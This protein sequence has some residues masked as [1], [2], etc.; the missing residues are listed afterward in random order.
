MIRS[1]R[2][3]SRFRSCAG[4]IA[5]VAFIGVLVA[6][7]IPVLRH[8]VFFIELMTTR[9]P[10]TVQIPVMGVAK[11]EIPNSWGFP[12]SGG[13]SHQGVDIFAKRG[14]P[15]LSSTDGIV[16]R[17]GTNTLGGQVVNVLGPGRQVHYYAHLDRYGSFREGD[18]VFA[19]S[20]IGYVGNTGNARDTPSHL[21]Y[22]V[23]DPAHGAI[24]PWPLL[25]SP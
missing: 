11:R 24:N 19:G 25:K 8:P 5:L 4:A 12:R 14:T 10:A 15:V 9:P 13:R 2:R 17:V 20:I 23:Y 21:H 7:W 3:V 16:V 22:G 6:I 1:S 18:I